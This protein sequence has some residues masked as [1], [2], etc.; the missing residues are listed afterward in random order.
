M[1][2]L[3]DQRA[4][5]YSHQTYLPKLVG[6]PPTSGGGVS[7]RVGRTGATWRCA[8]VIVLDVSLHTVENDQQRRVDALVFV[9]KRRGAGRNDVVG[10]VSPP[11]LQPFLFIF[12]RWGRSWVGLR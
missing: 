2:P 3:K 10:P 12:L 1:R 6:C 9:V 11:R 7:V 4:V 5:C 8:R